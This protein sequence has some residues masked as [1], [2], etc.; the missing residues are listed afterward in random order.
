LTPAANAHHAAELLSTLR[1][2][3]VDLWVDK[4]A[5]RFRA[6]VGALD[7]SLRARVA[8]LRA[9][10]IALLERPPADRRRLTDR[11]LRLWLLHQRH[12]ATP[13]YHMN[14]AFRMRGPLDVRR[15]RE[16]AD[17]TLVR[18]RALCSAVR[19]EDGTPV[20]VARP[21]PLPPLAFID[22]QGAPDAVIE[23][24]VAEF[25]ARPIDLRAGPL[26]RGAVIRRHDDE[27]VVVIVIHHLVCDDHAVR[28]VC[29]QILQWYAALADGTPPP[30]WAA[31]APSPGAAPLARS[32]LAALAS[33]R[34]A[35][36]TS[37]PTPRLPS[38]ALPASAADWS[39]GTFI[40]T[41]DAA[42][43]AH[44]DR[45]RRASGATSLSLALA[46]TAVAITA[47]GGPSRMLAGTP[48]HGRENAEDWRAVDY[49]SQTVV[50]SI[51]TAGSATF[52]EVL[53]AVSADLSDALL[54]RD[55]PY[56]SFTPPDLHSDAGG[57]VLW[58]V[59][60]AAVELPQL[61]G[62]QLEPLAVDAEPARHDLR[63]AVVDRHDRLELLVTFRRRTVDAAFAARTAAALEALLRDV[64]AR[65][66]PVGE[67][68]RRMGALAAAPA[69]DAGTAGQAL[70]AVARRRRSAG[71][72]RAC[73]QPPQPQ[74]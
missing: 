25:V 30:G 11:Q 29:T 21:E 28:I 39:A 26:A 5:L 52:S 6:P 7:D 64:P 10:V 70:A 4:G 2:R 46:L 22:L 53:S 48:F 1:E 24:A 74:S 45:R 62:L 69:L 72:H 42:A 13:E 27:H 33:S 35:L 61:T 40:A 63:V 36:L 34:R 17:A 66:A 9:E 50:T 37:G 57:H 20:L 31:V 23:Q 55:V 12:G 44:W 47:A 51:G 14:A 49:R 18:H 68:V 43:R 71:R 54:L 3:G 65:D 16:A 19:D 59:T 8:Q 15:L 38:P 41:L 60:Y 56:E 73:P 32:G 58:V 67:L